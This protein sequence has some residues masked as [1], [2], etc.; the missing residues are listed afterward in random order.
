MNTVNNYL[1]EGIFTSLETCALTIV[2][3]NGGVINDWH[4]SESLLWVEKNVEDCNNTDCYEGPNDN[5]VLSHR[6]V[7]L[8]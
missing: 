7:S 5:I 2:D 8:S 3:K 4:L 6:V 1:E